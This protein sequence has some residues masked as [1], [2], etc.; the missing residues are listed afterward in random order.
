MNTAKPMKRKDPTT[1]EEFR[2]LESEAA[3]QSWVVDYARAHS[4]LV[5]HVTDS[6]RQDTTGLP[7]LVLARGG[8]VILAELKSET[9]KVRPEQ[10]AWLAASGN[11]LWRP[12][13][14]QKITAMLV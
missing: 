8:L 1:T 3:F 5:A 6:R 9:G 4:W 14:R 7:D 11:H 12:S 13:D 10:E 2:L